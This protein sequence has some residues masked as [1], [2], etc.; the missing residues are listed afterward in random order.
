MLKSGGGGVIRYSSP[1]LQKLGGR[2]PPIP[3]GLTPMLVTFLT[4][5]WSGRVDLTTR[6]MH[7]E[8][9]TILTVVPY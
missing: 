5:F 9:L 6:I 3:P 1:P 2:V 8:N 7:S 4:A